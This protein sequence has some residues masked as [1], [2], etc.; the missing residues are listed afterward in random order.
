ML[1]RSLMTAVISISLVLTCCQST[2]AQ[3]GGPGGSQEVPVNGNPVNPWGSPS[4][5]FE[6]SSLVCYR[7]WNWQCSEVMDPNYQQTLCAARTCAQHTF[8]FGGIVHNTYLCSVPD[9][10]ASYEKR[11]RNDI[12]VP[13]VSVVETGGWS[14]SRSIVHCVAGFNCLCD[15]QRVGQPCAVASSPFIHEAPV[16]GWVVKLSDPCD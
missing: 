9:G 1:W 10:E 4:S 3:G 13:Y 15:E 7:T 16:T 11:V 14:T 12:E 5:P 8:V 6:P 2:M